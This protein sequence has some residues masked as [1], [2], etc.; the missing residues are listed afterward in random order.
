MLLP[1]VLEL[2]TRKDESP[3]IIM[4]NISEGQIQIANIENEQRFDSA[5][6]RPLAKIIEVLPNLEV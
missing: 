2:K 1:T 3:R 6:T 4:D 5:I